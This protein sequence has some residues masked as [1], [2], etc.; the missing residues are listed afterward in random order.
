MTAVRD[1][2][3]SPSPMFSRISNHPSGRFL[4]AGG[5]EING[6]GGGDASTVWRPLTYPAVLCGL[7]LPR[8]RLRSTRER[9]MPAASGQA[10]APERADDRAPPLLSLVFFA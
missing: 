5:E 2:A 9:A 8:L 1:P 4:R 6:I 7:P 10:L 3:P